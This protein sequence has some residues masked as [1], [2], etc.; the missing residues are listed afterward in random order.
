MLGNNYLK[1]NGV[2]I[3]NPQVFEPAYAT[4]ETIKTSEAGTDVVIPTRYNKRTIVMSFQ[5]TSTWKN[6]LLT[7]TERPTVTLLYKNESLTGRLRADKTTLKE[8]S[9]HIKGTDGLWTL[10]MKFFES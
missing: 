5:V 3:P 8:G 1:I 4:T 10:S 2:T 7:F 9:E 6:K